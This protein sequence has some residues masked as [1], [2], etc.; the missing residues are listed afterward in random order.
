MGIRYPTCE[1]LLTIKGRLLPNLPDVDA[2]VENV[3]QASKP[4]LRSLPKFCAYIQRTQNYNQV[5]LVL[6]LTL[7]LLLRP[8]HNTHCNI[9][10]WH[11]NGGLKA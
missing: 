4:R 11:R 8:C 7:S 1:I 10:S 5:E 6:Q 9:R 3:K 2:A